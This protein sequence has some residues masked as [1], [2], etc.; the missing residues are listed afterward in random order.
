MD[1]HPH[2]GITL[3]KNAI[4]LLGVVFFVIATNG[5]LTVLMGAVPSAITF[6]NGIGLPGVFVLIGLIYLLFSVGFAA[7]AHHI[8]NAGA[9]YAYVS[10]GLGHPLGVGAAFM[11]ITAYASLNLALYGMFGFFGSHLLTRITGLELPWWVVC[12]VF[13]IVVHFFST[14]NI[15]F[16]GKM[17]GT[18]ML[19]E[20]AIILVFD[21]GVFNQGGG[22]DGL[23]LAPFAPSNVFVPALGSAIVFVISAF[24]GFETAAIYAEEARDAK[25][26]VPLALYISVIVIMTLYAG[27]TWLLIA[28]Y[29]IEEAL[30]T[31]ANNPGEIWF[32]MSTKLV[33][34][35]SADVMDVL[36]TTSLF[37]AILSFQNTLSRYLFSLGREGVI[38]RGFAVL[39]PKQQTPTIASGFQSVLMIAGIV[40]AGLYSLDPLTVLMPLAATPASIGIVVVQFLAALA[41]VGF[42]HTSK[43][44]ANLF[45]RLIAPS[46]SAIALG[47]V[48][49]MMLMNVSLLTGGNPVFD[50]LLPTS[51]FAIGLFGVAYAMWLK[52]NRPAVYQNLA[53][54]LNEV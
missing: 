6:G 18:L 34:A 1:L 26:T 24:T 2:D 38:W 40:A 14:R 44:D 30:K 25:R 15:Q 3:R 33:G 9:F 12:A 29:G 41:V 21:A 48:L 46:V 16:N 43:R 37:A 4:G 52:R 17:L 54:V 32:T 50:W 47:A 49:I 10:N 20:I 39:H 23:T 7:M 51:V 11:A 36:M 42:F 45:Q 8:K 35:W 19:A 31:A 28:A 22:P 53:R 13:A 5:P 27:S